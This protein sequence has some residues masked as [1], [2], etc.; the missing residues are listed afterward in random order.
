M[1]AWISYNAIEDKW[2][3]ALEL[4]D[5]IQ[6]MVEDLFKECQIEEYYEGK[7]LICV[8]KYACCRCALKEKEAIEKML[9]T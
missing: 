7:D 4:K 6:K 2:T 8:S 5:V 3:S 1:G 9:E